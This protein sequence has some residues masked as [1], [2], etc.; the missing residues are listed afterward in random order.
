MYF[1]ESGWG[2]V[3][4]NFFYFNIIIS[5]IFPENVTKIHQVVQR[6]WRFTP[7]ILTLFIYFLDLLTFPYYKEINGVTNNSKQMMSANFFFQPTLNG[8]FN[9]LTFMFVPDVVTWV[10]ISLKC[11]CDQKEVVQ[12]G[13]ASRGFGRHVD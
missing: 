4:F 11:A 13:N 8:L 9:F 6:I 1:S 3:F 12:L 7:S 2:P 10:K 5:H